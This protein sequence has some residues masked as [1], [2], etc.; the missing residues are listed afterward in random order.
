MYLYQKLSETEKLLSQLTELTDA[1]ASCEIIGQAYIGL[2]VTE[3][4]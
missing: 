3:T 4:I 1:Q 2:D